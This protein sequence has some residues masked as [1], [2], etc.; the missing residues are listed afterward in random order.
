MTK[1]KRIT[2]ITAIMDAEDRLLLAPL[3]LYFYALE[4]IIPPSRRKIV[5]YL[6]F[7]K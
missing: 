7:D 6:T 4:G 3:T 5:Y 1:A 2:N